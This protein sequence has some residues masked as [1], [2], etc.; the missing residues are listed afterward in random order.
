MMVSKA[1]GG[2]KAVGRWWIVMALLLSLG[3]NVGLLLSRLWDRPADPQHRERPME[4]ERPRG[5]DR[6]RM[7]RFEWMSHELGLDSEQQ[8]LFS[9]HQRAFFQQTFEGRARV[10][11]L[12]GELR[13]EL[14][15]ENPDRRRLDTLLGELSTAHADLERG[16]VEHLLSTRELLEPEQQRQ[17]LR[18]IGRLRSPSSEFHRR[19]GGRFHGPRPWREP[20]RRSG[21]PE[22]PSPREGNSGD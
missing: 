14:V 8:E 13:R 10:A 6:G 9:E 17:F 2:N 7:D 11:Q 19:F 18:L 4:R 3:I 1:P 5:E 15:S 22:P 20:R 21:H 16:F 12:Q